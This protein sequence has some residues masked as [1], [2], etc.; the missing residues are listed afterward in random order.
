MAYTQSFLQFRALTTPLRVPTKWEV[1][2]T[3]KRNHIV[4]KA[5]KEDVED[6]DA[7]N[8][9]L[10]SRRLALGTALIGGAAAAGTKA[11]PAR[12]VDAT[13]SLQEPPTTLPASIVE[14]LPLNRTSFPEGFVFGTASAAYQYEGAAFDYGRKPSVWD[15]FTHKYPEKI[16]DR[17]NGDVAVDEY[18]R[19][20]EDIQIMKDMNLDAYRF[21]I[22]W[23]RILPNGKVGENEEGVN[24]EGI[25]YYNRL[26]DH[27]KDNDI[28]PYVTLF[29]WDFPQA[30]EEEYGGFLNPRVVDDFRNYANICFKYF[31]NRVKH[32]ITLNEPWAYSREGYSVGMFAPGRC[33]ETVDSTCLGGDSGTEPYIVTHH[34][35]LAHAAAVDLYKKQYKDDQKGEIGITLISR[36]FEPYS[37]TEADKKAAERALDFL[38]GWYM[39]PLTSGKYPE[40]MRS[41]VGRRLPEFTAEESRLLAGSFDFLG[42]N[43]YTT[44]YAADQPSS[45][46][47]P[48][49]ETDANVN[50]LTERNGIPVGTPTASNW[51]FVCPKGFKD[52]LLYV[53]EKYN[54]PLIYITENGRG[55]DVNDEGQ[56]REEALL[57]I[58]RIDYYYRHLYYLRSAM[59]EEVNVKGYFAWSLLDNFEWKNGYLVGFGLNYV[60]RNDDLKRYA[61]LSARWFKSFLQRPDPNPNYEG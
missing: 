59:S 47:N 31:G 16:N 32:W 50:Y 51:L 14:V 42:L 26:I 54:N 33:S 49:Y 29:H 58:Y 53:K 12:A 27:L 13:L 34:L 10:V 25:A 24:Q 7:T 30:L 44:N 28:E 15:N 60:D 38:F 43:Y 1:M 17:S 21:S 40:S 61:K 45:N 3:N 39:Q 57:D 22:S 5:V 6:S 23:S 11:S 19:Y 36:W 37:N 35:L 46:L 41:L 48:S 2:G 9:S 56:T 4:C 8:V 20:K 55:N 52:L 18:H